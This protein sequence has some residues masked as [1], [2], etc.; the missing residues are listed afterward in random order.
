MSKLREF[1]AHFLYSFGRA[2]EALGVKVH[3]FKDKYLV[4]QL[5]EDG[6]WVKWEKFK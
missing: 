5:L 6:D 4:G 2:F 3:P 1:I